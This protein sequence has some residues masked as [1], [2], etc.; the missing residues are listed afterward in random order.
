M[1]LTD[2]GW[3]DFFN[4][5]F[6]PYRSGGLVPARVIAQHRNR[7]LAAGEPGEMAAEVSGKFRHQTKDRSG[8]PAVGDW[9][10]LEPFAEDRGLIHAVLE[11]RS[12]FIRKASGDL[13]EAQVV[14]ANID[15]VFLITGLD[16]DFNLRRTERYL[17]TAWDSGASPVIVLNKRDLCPNIDEVVREVE[18]IALGTPVLAVSARDGAN[19]DALMGCLGPGKTAALLGSSG[20]GKSTL[21]NRLLGIE[22][23]PTA[24]VR[25][26]D[27]HGRHTTS[28]GEL[29]ALPG[30]GLLID[31]PGMRELQLWADEDSLAQAFGDIEKLAAGCRFTDCRHGEEPGCAVRQAIAD[32]GLDPGRFESYLKQRRELRHLALKQDSRARRQSE[33]EFGRKI[34]SLMKDVKLRKPSY[35]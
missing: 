12:V 2:L 9:V 7:C 31:T 10:A 26:Q 1:K 20:V 15:I 33:K 30:G 28:S 14:A 17:T 29:I 5:L 25:R 24:P 27:S 22:R 35:R 32:G 11:R 23:Q 13:T 3:N 19:L 18:M 34:A 4:D 8:Y 16:G 21:I 6:E